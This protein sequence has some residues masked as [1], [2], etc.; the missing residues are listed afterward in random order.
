MKRIG[1]RWT[2]R[3][4]AVLV[5][6]SAAPAALAQ[7]DGKPK[8]LV[9]DMNPR[10]PS[11]PLDIKLA[12]Y[13]CPIC[14]KDGKIPAAPPPD[15]KDGELQ[16]MH[17]PVSTVVKQVEVTETWMA[18]QTPHFKIL[19]TL[20]PANIKFADSLY[21][22]ADIERLKTI[23]PKITF[24]PDGVH[25]DAHQRLHLYHCRLEREYTHFSALTG[26]TQPNLGMEAPYEVYLFSD[27]TNHHNLC[28]RYIGGRQ[29]KGGVQWHIQDSPRFMLFTCSESMSATLNGKGDGIL[30]NH[31]FHNV[32][33]IMMDGYNSYIRETPAWLEEGIGH[34]YERREN[35]R[36][37]NFCWAEGAAPRD[38]QK[39][40]WETTIFS[41]V[42]RDRDKDPAFST[43]C[44]LLQ[45]GEMTGVENGLSWGVVKWMID[46][47]PLRFTKMI[48]KMDDLKLNMRSADM[49]QEGF[50]VTP[51]VLYQRWR[52]Y[53]VAN[54]GGK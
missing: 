31:V 30:S 3:A 38:F 15:V 5:L 6:G 14:I 16:M 47:E 25:L 52:E 23:T 18:I 36:W 39:P 37:N 26:N 28:D 2:W 29:D 9:E 11:T 40:D 53:V 54:W 46:T 32:A 24:L 19:S 51:S 49:I 41:L 22:K 1:M 17:R 33:H 50:G 10:A 21:C 20:G 4:A 12:P 13:W 45:P 27:Y 48:E 7:D 42:R 35:P 34:Y 43:W 8:T 44:E